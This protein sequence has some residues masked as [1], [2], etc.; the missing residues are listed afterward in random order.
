MSAV[1]DS[2]PVN[3][4][5]LRGAHERW[6]AEERAQ[7]LLRS[8]LSPEQRRQ[9]DERRSFEVVGNHSYRI[10][11]GDIFNIQELDDHGIQVSALC[12]TADRIAMGDI[13]LAQKIALETFEN[14]VLAIANRTC[15]IVWPRS[16]P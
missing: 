11:K 1:C 15:G 12:V 10:C 2:R 7:E 16:N 4:A 14:R 8:W 6:A 5:F 9:Y 3:K 13:N